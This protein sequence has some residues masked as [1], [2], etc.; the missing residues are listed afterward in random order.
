MGRGVTP[1]LILSIPR[2]QRPITEAQMVTGASTAST[3]YHYRR[4][5]V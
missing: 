5:K 4:M 1:P 2:L 3:N